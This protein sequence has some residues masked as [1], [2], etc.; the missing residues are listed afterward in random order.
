[1][2]NRLNMFEP[3]TPFDRQQDKLL[4]ESVALQNL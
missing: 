2:I 1:M 4:D 3:E